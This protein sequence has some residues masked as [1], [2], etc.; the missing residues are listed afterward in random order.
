MLAPAKHHQGKSERELVNQILTM[1]VSTR[2][3]V[4]RT[5]NGSSWRCV[6]VEIAEGAGTIPSKPGYRYRNY[7]AQ[8]MA[9]EFPVSSCRAR[10]ISAIPEQNLG[11]GHCLAGDQ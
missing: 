10:Q 5:Q 6:L 1:G 2:A 8:I 11:T 7:I 9:Y 3:V 4:Q